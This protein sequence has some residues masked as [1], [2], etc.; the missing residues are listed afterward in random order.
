MGLF[1]SSSTKADDAARRARLAELTTVAKRGLSAFAETGHALAEIQRDELWR[2]V[3]PTWAQWCSETLGL[4]AERAGQLMRAAETAHTLREIGKV[5]R[6]E[7]AARELS[8]LP[9]EEQKAAWSEAL[10]EAGDK[11]PTVEQVAKAARKRKPKA[12]RRTTAKP[13]NYRVPGAAVR[14]VPRRNGFVSY[15]EALRHALALAEKAE[16]EQSQPATIRVA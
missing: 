11:E 6:S 7:R 12:K 8:G 9:A 2:L 14:V 10:A 5:P 13:S 15:V 1:S 16:R 3:S 4:T